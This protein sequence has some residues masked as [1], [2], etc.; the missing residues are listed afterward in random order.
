MNGKFII[1]SYVRKYKMLLIADI[2]P[3]LTRFKVEFWSLELKSL[4]L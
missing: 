3:I 4:E 1:S 2:W